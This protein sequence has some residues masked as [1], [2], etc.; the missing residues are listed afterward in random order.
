MRKFINLVGIV[1]LY[2]TGCSNPVENS[3]EPVVP[4]S[5]SFN[6]VMESATDST[7]VYPNELYV[8]KLI[9]GSLGG[10]L[11][12][13]GIYV[14]SFGDIVTVKA[15]LTVPAGAYK[16]NLLISMRTDSNLPA[17]E[18]KPRTHFDLPL[19]LDLK[20]TGMR[21]IRYG[22]EHGKTDFIYIADDGSQF[23]IKHD[24]LNVNLN[25]QRAEVRGAKL[26]HFSRY[27]FIRKLADQ[28]SN[29]IK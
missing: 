15:T 11:T 26:Y 4:R 25:E 24:G 23:L 16:K 14:N 17:L 12:M 5:S 7:P 10:K 27:G 21:L 8:E 9:D 28:N 29:S 1:A 22:L 2:F 20:F 19:K 13:E 18:F 3:M 6:K